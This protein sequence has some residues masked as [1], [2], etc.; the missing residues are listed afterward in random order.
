LFLLFQR[1]L[2]DSTHPL[3]SAFGHPL[4]SV[5]SGALG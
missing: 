5:A 4:K 3:W 2:V 1:T